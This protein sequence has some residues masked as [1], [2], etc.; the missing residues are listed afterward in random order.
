MTRYRLSL[1]SQNITSTNLLNIFLEFPRINQW[2]DGRCYQYMYGVD[3]RGQALSNEIRPL[4]KVDMKDGTSVTWSELGC[5]CGEPVFVPLPNA[6]SE[7]EG[8]ILSI[9]RNSSK[10]RSFLLIL[11]AQNLKEI[12]RAEIPL[13]IPADLHGQYFN[14]D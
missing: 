1:D 2:Y 7:D 5:C 11:D 4:Y 6:K 12:G 10:K 8:V 3:P 13:L 9:M 14:S